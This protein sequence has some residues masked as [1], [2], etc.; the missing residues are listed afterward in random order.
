[1]S[2]RPNRRLQKPERF[3]EFAGMAVEMTVIILLSVFLGRWLDRTYPP[4]FP[5]Y[6]LI[7]SL[8]G[9]IFALYRFIS[10]L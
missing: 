5:L 6:T 1:M 4:D 9:V 10:K 3:L 7:C 2:N 8:G